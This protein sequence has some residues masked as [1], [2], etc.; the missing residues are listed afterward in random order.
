[1]DMKYFLNLQI[2]KKV[3]ILLV[4]LVSS[5]LLNA[6]E[7]KTIDS[8]SLLFTYKYSFCEEKK[9]P[10]SL[11]V[12]EMVLEV[13]EKYSKFY[14]TS[15]QFADSLYAVYANESPEVAFGIIL[16]KV[17]NLERHPFSRFYVF[18]RYPNEEETA[19]ISLDMGS[20]SRY[21]VKEAIT[22]SWKIDNNAKAVVLGYNCTKATC[23]YGGRNYEAW[24]TTEIPISDGPYKFS[25]LP[26]LIVKIS[27]DNKE[28][29]FELHE[30][31]NVKPTPMIFPENRY[32]ETNAKNFVKA[33]EASKYD[34]IKRFENMQ[35]NSVDAHIKAIAKVHRRNNFI[36][37]Y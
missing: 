24:F 13:G 21:M 26:G 29:N 37:Q 25:G 5:K 10:Q 2:I 11:R 31:K 3:S 15:N 33:L 35:V 1:M 19:F 23:S 4:L 36:E 30:I 7:Y 27:D 20:S 8:Y 32:I 6:Q 14:S 12:S 22:F 18:K 34:L 17:R 16:P 28:H 9:N